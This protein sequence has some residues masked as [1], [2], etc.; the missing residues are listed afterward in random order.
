MVGEDYFTSRSAKRAAIVNN[1]RTLTIFRVLPDNNNVGI[2]EG[3]F[4]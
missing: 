1:I 3:P 2:G 4:L